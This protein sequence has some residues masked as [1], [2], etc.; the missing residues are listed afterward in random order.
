M[1]NV[2]RKTFGSSFSP[3]YLIPTSAII[4]TTDGTARI[5]VPLYAAA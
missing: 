2:Q 1:D 4:S 5:F 3:C